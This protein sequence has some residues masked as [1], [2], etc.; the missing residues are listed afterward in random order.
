MFSQPQV[1]MVLV[2]VM[3][4]EELSSMSPLLAAVLSS[5]TVA[6]LMLQRG[7]NAS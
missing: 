1:Q 7:A 5:L 2:M 3:L 4:G 6:K